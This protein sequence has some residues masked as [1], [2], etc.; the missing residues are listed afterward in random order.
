MQKR[1]AI[2]DGVVTGFADEVSFEGLEVELSTKTRVSH[3]LPKSLGARLF[4][5]VLRV[6]FGETGRVAQW[7]REW[8]CD[9]LVFIDGCRFGPY[10]DRQAAIDFE[11][12]EIY[13]LGKITR[14]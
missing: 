13:R 3:I 2:K 7:T 5:M 14:W 11:K 12:Q 8:G 1:I 10:S 9:W 4:F 6:L